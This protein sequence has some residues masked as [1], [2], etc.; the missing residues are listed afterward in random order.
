[1]WWSMTASSF[2]ARFCVAFCLISITGLGAA[3]QELSPLPV[4]GAAASGL[5]A[6]KLHEH[7]LL[8]NFDLST[9]KP[10]TSPLPHLRRFAAMPAS[11]SRAR[12]TV[13]DMIGAAERRYGLPMGLLDALIWTESAYRPNVV[14]E[15]GAAGLAQLMPKTAGELGVVDRLDPQ[16]SIYGGAKY[17]RQMLERFQS[18]N[19]A[20]AAYN[21]GPGNVDKFGGVPPF[22]ETIAYIAN[23][24]GRRAQL[25]R[26]ARKDM[27]NIEKRF[28]AR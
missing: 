2:V 26:K 16:S 27:H 14:S 11:T 23:V 28:F 17:L 18:V 24:I 10:E 4:E 12:S 15:V 5:D 22:P 8:D 21:A 7:R 3:T 19:L 25:V 20:L 1:M 6:F 13:V 9:L